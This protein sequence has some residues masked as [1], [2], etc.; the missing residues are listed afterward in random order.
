MSIDT[1]PTL[2]EPSRYTLIR[3]LQQGHLL[4]QNNGG[5]HLVHDPY[6]GMYLIEKMLIPRDIHSGFATR[7][8]D[9]LYQLRGHPNITHLVQYELNTSDRLF[10]PSATIWTEFCEIGSLSDLIKWMSYG[11]KKVY[12]PEMFLWHVLRSLVEAVRYCQRG[13]A[14]NE[15]RDPKWNVIYHRDIQP[16]NVFLACGGKSDSDLPR[17]LLGDFG[18][19]TSLRDIAAGKSSPFHTERYDYRFAPPEAPDFSLRSDVY[20][21][22]LV[23]QCLMFAET[24]PG[25]SFQCLSVDVMK[26]QMYSKSLRYIVAACLQVEIEVRPT[27]EQLVSN[28]AAKPEVEQFDWSSFNEVVEFSPPVLHYCKSAACQGCY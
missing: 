14:E 7:E 13:G 21:I 11:D 23:M 3:D 8:I 27:V 12:M 15:K 24:E 4:G 2:A 28:L 9:I 22:G 25:N 5:I 19:S 1:V 16:S 10:Q 26:N 18:C 20:Q 6:I 17:V